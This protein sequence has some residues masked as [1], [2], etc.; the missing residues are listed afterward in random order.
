MKIP[1]KN[2]YKSSVE[3]IIENLY[4]L[5]SP[6]KV[7]AYNEEKEDKKA[8]EAKKAELKRIEEAKMKENESN[9]K[10][11][12]KT[13]AEK[14]VTQIINNIQI[15]IKNIH[16]RFEDK[17]SAK[18]PFAFGVSLA[19]FTALTVDSAGNP[20]LATEDITQV[21]K[22]VALE[23]LSVYLNCNSQ[24]Y[25]EMNHV[26]YPKLFSDNIASRDF[27]PPNFN[28]GN[29]QIYFIIYNINASN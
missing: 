22:K 20:T 15:K 7:V 2:L 10:P 25:S 14:L 26:E 9:A 3:V 19:G 8:F 29:Y 13:F 4:L 6:N 5:S 23:G 11:I 16:I 24:L 12:D 17:S 28:Y 1:W 27:I 21:F 18:K